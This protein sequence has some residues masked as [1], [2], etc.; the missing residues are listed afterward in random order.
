MTN[1][2][3]ALYTEANYSEEELEY[4][5]VVNDVLQDLSL[6]GTHSNCCGETILLPD[7]CSQCKEHCENE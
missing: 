4:Y 2:E 6:N 1:D 7:V 3:Q 5:R